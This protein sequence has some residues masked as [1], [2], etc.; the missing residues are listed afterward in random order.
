[1]KILFVTKPVNPELDEGSKK[2]SW[3]IA[4]F[5]KNHQFYLMT[6]HNNKPL[7]TSHKARLIF[8]KVYND[9]NFNYLQKLRLVVFLLFCN[10][11]VSVYHYFF[12]PTLIS[13]KVLWLITK[14]KKKKSIQSIPSLYKTDLSYNSLKK[15]CFADKIVVY[16]NHTE[17]ALNNNGIYNVIKINAG[18]NLENY[19]KAP[20]ISSDRNIY[21]FSFGRTIVLFSGEL[22][23]LNSVKLLFSIIQKV[24]SARSDIDFVMASPIR[25]SKDIRSLKIIE[26][27][28]S[29]NRLRNRVHLFKTVKNF[30]HLLS[31]CDI[32]LYPVSSM[33]GKIDT[34]LTVLE[35]MASEL[36]IIISDIEPL[37]EILKL[38]AGF[39][40]APEDT[41]SFANA[42]LELADDATLR[43]Q[44]GQE[45]RRIIQKHYDLDSMIRGYEKLYD[46]LA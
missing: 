32:F 25:S 30:S 12:V 28:I 16:S 37:N 43:G 20:K 40:V 31:I 1:M 21:N 39:A 7:L 10:D 42:I 19:G 18:V 44:M 34:P 5:C 4:S 9:K 17:K 2:N 13:S 41:N 36:P 23:R 33:V 27:E 14:L 35:A 29:T 6:Y 22:S 3:Q 38:R 24:V 11:G 45:A 8:K 46:E 15:L 26:N